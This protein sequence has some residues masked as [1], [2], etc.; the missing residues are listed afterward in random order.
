MG[1]PRK[2]DVS[3]PQLHDLMPVWPR[4]CRVAVGKERKKP[5]DGTRANEQLRT[6]YPCL[7]CEVQGISIAGGIGWL[8]G[9]TP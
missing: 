7:G 2:L 9:T 6:A 4:R 5:T 8:R 3:A 1:L